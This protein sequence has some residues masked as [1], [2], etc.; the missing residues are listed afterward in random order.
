MYLNKDFVQVWS[1]RVHIGVTLK[2]KKPWIRGAECKVGASKAVYESWCV[3]EPVI[4]Y[5]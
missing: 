4:F 2:K 1:T 5:F 3:S